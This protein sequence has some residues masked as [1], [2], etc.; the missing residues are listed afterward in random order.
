[1]TFPGWTVR[2]KWRASYFRAH[3]KPSH[4]AIAIRP[5]SASEI[6]YAVIGS[7]LLEL[8]VRHDR[9]GQRS[10]RARTH[11]PQTGGAACGRGL[12]ATPRADAFARAG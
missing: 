6:R 3:E 7:S 1:V 4:I 9:K 5:T 10:F 8:G 12:H 2:S 11:I